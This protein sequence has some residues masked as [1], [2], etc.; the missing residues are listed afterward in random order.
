MKNKL[1]PSQVA[2]Q[3]WIDRFE[4]MCTSFEDCDGELTDALD[5]LSKQQQNAADKAFWK[6]HKRFLKM[7]YKGM[8]K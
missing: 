2:R 4:G 7:L 5:G 6:L 8:P 3:H 1:T